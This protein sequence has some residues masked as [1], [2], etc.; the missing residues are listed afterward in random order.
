[1]FPKEGFSKKGF[2]AKGLAVRQN[3]WLPVTRSATISNWT[4]NCQDDRPFLLD[5]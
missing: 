1:M 3:D 5:P 4:D 2:G